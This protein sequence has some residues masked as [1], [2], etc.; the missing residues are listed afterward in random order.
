MTESEGAIEAS[1]LPKPKRMRICWHWWVAGAFTALLMLGIGAA[2]E[3]AFRLNDRGPEFAVGRY[4]GALVA[5][6][7]EKA[8]RLSGAKAGGGDILLTDAAYAK[9]TGRISGFR[10]ESQRVDGDTATVIVSIEQGSHVYDQSFTTRRSGRQF[11]F[12]DAWT[13]RPATLTTIAAKVGAP[14]GAGLTVAG[15][16]FDDPSLSLRAFPGTYEAKAA[17]TSEYY[18]IP[19]FSLTAIG[20]GRARNT[21]AQP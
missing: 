1:A 7:A 16:K 18:G 21:P 2:V 3:I 13:L 8:L 19:A 4:F 15:Q 5:G 11:L 14:S 20:F 6:S 17:S 10:I 9:A 12:F